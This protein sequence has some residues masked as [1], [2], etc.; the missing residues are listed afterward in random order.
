[1]KQKTKPEGYYAEGD[2][3]VEQAKANTTQGLSTTDVAEA[4]NDAVA[5]LQQLAK[6]FRE[7]GGSDSIKPQDIPKNLSY[8][9]KMIDE[10][11]RLVSFVRG[12]PD[13]RIEAQVEASQDAAVDSFL[14]GFTND[15]VQQMREWSREN[16]E[17]KAA[18]DAGVVGDS[19]S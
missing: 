3:I 17:R 10:V 16:Q 1:M 19:A 12:G 2:A 8:M 13:S 11:T 6:R 7:E 15:Q 18:K 9:A 4:I 14:R 5:G